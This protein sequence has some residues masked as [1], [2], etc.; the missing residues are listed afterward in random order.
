MDLWAQYHPASSPPPV[1]NYK[2]RSQVIWYDMDEVIP[3]EVAPNT[4]LPTTAIFHQNQWFSTY[5]HSTPSQLSF[6]D[7]P[8]M[9]PLLWNTGPVLDYIV[10][11]TVYYQQLLGPVSTIYFMIFRQVN[12][13]HA[14]MS[15]KMIALELVPLVWLLGTL[16]TNSGSERPGQWILPPN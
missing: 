13:L 9:H 4:L 7:T 8:T 14:V 10:N 6:M 2:T 5:F 11:T 3:C 16:T 15:H 12:W 1:S